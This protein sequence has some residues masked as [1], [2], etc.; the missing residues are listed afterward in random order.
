MLETI[1]IHVDDEYAFKPKKPKKVETDVN[2]K[3]QEIW[4]VKMPWAKPISNEVG[5]VSI[6]KCRVSTIIKRKGKKL[7]A[8]WDSIEKHV[9]KRKGLDGKWI[10]DPKCMH[11]KNETSYAQ[12]S[13]T[14]I[15]Q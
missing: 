1:V 2:H 4:V 9:G 13:T 11:V 8:K 5:V 10:M 6:M 15:L 14:T 7:V 12:L 3:F